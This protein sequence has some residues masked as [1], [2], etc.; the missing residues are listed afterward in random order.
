MSRAKSK[1]W[2]GRK[3]TSARAYWAP[4][5]PLP[6]WRPGC[7]KMLTRYSKWTV[8]H[9]IDRHFGGSVTDPS[10]QWPE[11]LKCNTSA[12]GRLGAA[13]T[14]AKRPVVAARLASERD[15]GIRG[16]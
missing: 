13:I 6:C 16:W 15:R 5:L 8:G 7:G 10:N 2:S 14:N 12:G 4:R 11:C 3:V 1:Q 9:I